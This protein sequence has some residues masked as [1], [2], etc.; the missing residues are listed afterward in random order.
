MLS[1]TTALEEEGYGVGEHPVE[2]MLKEKRG[3]KPEGK[4]QIGGNHY[5]KMAITPTNYILANNIGWL[6]G[7]AIKYISRHQDKNGIEDLQKAIHYIELI[8]EKERQ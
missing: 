8:I 5:S 6:E 2:T 4:K 3:V 1:N 7:N